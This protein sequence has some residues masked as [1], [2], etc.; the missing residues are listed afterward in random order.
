MDGGEF[1]AV[2]DLVR[3]APAEAGRGWSPDSDEQR[4][5]LI[6]C[7]RVILYGPIWVG[8]A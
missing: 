8:I 2:L 5:R 3:A 4:P 1:G 7:D 6:A